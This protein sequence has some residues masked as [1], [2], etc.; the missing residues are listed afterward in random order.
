MAVRKYFDKELYEK[1]DAI[2]K[3]FVQ[4]LV[5]GTEFQIVTNIKKRQVDMLVYKDSKL[6]GYVEV[7]KKLVW[8]GK[9][10]PYEDVNFPS[11]K[12]KLCQL[13]LPTIFV[14]INEDNSA[15]L[16]VRGKD[17]LASPQ[18]EVHNKYVGAGEIFYKVPKD[19][20]LFN[21]LIDL[22]KEL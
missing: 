5:K 13:E 18:A 6:I 20:V 14:M 3:E 10:F 16:T 8:K 12:A 4:S 15:Y 21:N 22:L 7:E 19:K 2:A 1:N 17:F 11:R 9:E